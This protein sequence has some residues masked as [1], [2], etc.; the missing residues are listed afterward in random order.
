MAQI[1]IAPW[2][3]LYDQD[4]NSV[5]SSTSKASLNGKLYAKIISSLDG[6][7]LQHMISRSHLHA[8]GIS[9]LQ[10]LHQI[11][12][13]KNVP[14]VIAAKTAEFWGN[15]KRFPHETVDDYHNRFHELLND[16]KDTDE[17]IS[18]RSAIRHFLFTLGTE[19]EPLQH[20]YRLG[21]ISEEWKTQDWP[22][23][24]VLCRDFYNS[25]N[26]KGP[27]SIS[28]RDRDPF[29]ELPIDRAAHHK[30]IRQWLMNPS[31]FSQ[32][33]KNEQL[34]FPGK[35]IYHL[36]S[37]HPTELCNVKRECDKLI[38]A[39]KTGS[40]NPNSAQSGGTTGQLRHITEEVFEDA[41]DSDTKDECVEDNDTNDSDL[42]YFARVSNHYL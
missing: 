1:S 16:L 31:R 11:Y 17:I 36:I 6:S 18:T 33:I 32:E 29:S 12:R 24:L 25:V 8:N 10:E 2:K 38:N 41:I 21:S 20:N 13:P 26:P 22:T 3:E 5:V 35:C 42:L 30:K 23:L 28:K 27:T 40:A 34:K 37:T 39:K 9:L 7:A 14:E 4:T 15:T 19:F